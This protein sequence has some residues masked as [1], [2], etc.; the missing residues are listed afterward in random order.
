MRNARGVPVLSRGMTPGVIALVAV[1]IVVTPL[2]V[3]WRRRQGQLRP[4][5]ARGFLRDGWAAPGWA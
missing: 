2:G 5:R 4:G 1:L 3:I